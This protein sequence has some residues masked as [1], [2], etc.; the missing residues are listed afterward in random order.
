MW[1]FVAVVSYFLLA[2]VALV[3]KYLLSGPGLSP[4][5]YAFYTGILGGVVFVLI[6]FGFL[7][8]PSFAIIAIALFAGSMRTLAVFSLFQGLKN[9]E[10]SR[11]IPSLGGAVPIFLAVLTI[12][13]AGEREILSLTTFAAFVLLVSGTILVSIEK[14][15]LVTLRSLQYSLGAALFFSLFFF[16]SKIVFEEHSFISGLIWLVAG[17]FLSSLLFLASK[18][19]RREVF[20]KKRKMPRKKGIILVGNQATAG[21]AVVLQN[22]AIALAPFGLLPFVGALGGTQYIFL[23]I[24]ALFVSLKFPHVLREKITRRVIIQKVVSLLLVG[25]GLVLLA[26]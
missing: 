11:I 24:L 14:R 21:G 5:T 18:Q 17:G 10:A 13:V 2:G 26:L 8:I 4:K 16:L 22:Y 6:P 1:I 15:A 20:G 9:F 25:V 23:F 12:F 19:V 3:D 7:E